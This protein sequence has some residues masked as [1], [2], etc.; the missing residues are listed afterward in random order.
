M[1]LGGHMANKVLVVED[2]PHI[3]DLV[4]FH[5][6]LEGL[7]VEAVGTGDDA[8]RIA[9]EEPFDVVVLDYTMPLMDGRETL[10]K[11]SER[12]ITPP[13]VVIITG[14]PSRV[15]ADNL[16]QLGVRALLAKPVRVAELVR[17]LVRFQDE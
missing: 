17:T 5:L 6:D 15:R 14:D 12:G 2:E 9:G 10:E 11:L 8:L 7:S 13:P 3:R 16:E 4:R 1:L